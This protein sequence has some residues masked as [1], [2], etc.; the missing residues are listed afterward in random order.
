MIIRKPNIYEYVCDS[1]GGLIDIPTSLALCGT[2]CV[3][4]NVVHKVKFPEKIEVE[5]EKLCKVIV[6]FD[7]KMLD[8]TNMWSWIR[9]EPIWILRTNGWS[10]QIAVKTCPVKGKLLEKINKVQDKNNK[11]MH[12]YLH[13]LGY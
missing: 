1:C 9:N 2:E 6:K 8:V 5:L 12:L 13:S 3:H 11:E 4:C 7:G 10:G